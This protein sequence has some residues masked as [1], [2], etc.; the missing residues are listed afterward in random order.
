MENFF[1][2]FVPHLYPINKDSHLGFKDPKVSPYYEDLEQWRGKLPPALFTVGSMDALLEDSVN[3]C[4]RWCMAGGQG[5]L[6]ILE[7]AVHGYLGFD[8]AIY[9]IAG[10]GKRFTADFIRETMGD[11]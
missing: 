3:M 10:V 11:A 9:P 6:K 4:T 5:V 7:G 8:E 2:A 1:S